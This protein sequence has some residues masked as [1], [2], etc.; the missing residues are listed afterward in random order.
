MQLINLFASLLIACAAGSASATTLKWHVGARCT[1]GVIETVSD[2]KSGQCILLGQGRTARSISF[3][4]AKGIEFFE[5]GGKHDACT[6]GAQASSTHN[7]GCVT[8][9]AGFNWAS[10]RESPVDGFGWRCAGR[11]GCNRFSVEGGL[12]SRGTDRKETITK[13]RERFGDEHSAAAVAR[14]AAGS[15]LEARKE[16]K[17]RTLSIFTE[18]QGKPSAV[19]PG[20]TNSSIH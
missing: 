19:L 5:S 20:N 1:G 16:L 2:G 6:N 10:V 7:S 12:D 9:P 15:E 3:N 13:T 17:A 8:A 18:H 11:G 14:L 4:G